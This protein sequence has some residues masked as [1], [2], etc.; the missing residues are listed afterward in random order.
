MSDKILTIKDELK[1]LREVSKK[2]TLEEIERLDLKNRLREANDTAWTK[3]CGLASIQIG[4]P[5]RYAWFT[6]DG[7]EYELINPEIIMGLGKIKYEEGCLSIPDKYTG[8]ERYYEIEYFS[9]GKKKRAKGHK[10]HIIQHEIDHM[11]GILN[12][13]KELGNEDDA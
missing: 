2:T 1:K 6:Y 4:I 13:D 7:K 11:N 8:V 12:I 10:A 5:L 3:G 9:N